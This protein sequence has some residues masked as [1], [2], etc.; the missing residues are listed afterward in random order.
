SSRTPERAEPVVQVGTGDV[1]RARIPVMLHTPFAPWSWLSADRL[2]DEPQTFD[3]VLDQTRRLWALI[4]AKDV[5]ALE[6]A[7]AEQA[8]DW[9]AAYSLP[10]E[11]AGQQMLGVARTLG[12]PDVVPMP[13]PDPASLSLE[14]LGFGRL[15]QLV[16]AEGKGPITLTVKGVAAMTGRFQAILCRR[17]GAWT[18]IR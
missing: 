16:D 11:A 3:E 12:D 1:V 15:A 10:D 8:R 6:A 17:E 2:A 5:P 9:Q 7:C 18:M 13:F 14:I 4:Q